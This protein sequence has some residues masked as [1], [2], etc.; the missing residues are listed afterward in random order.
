MHLWIY[1]D[2]AT[3]F[4]VGHVVNE[5]RQFGI[6]D[7]RRVLELMQE[8]WIAVLGRMHTLR[9]DLEGAWRNKEANERLSDMQI[10]LDIY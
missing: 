1:V 2:E 3:K 10:I 5:G 6:M 7:V 4:T 8:R 9:T